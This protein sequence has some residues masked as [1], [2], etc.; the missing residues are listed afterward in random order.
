MYVTTAPPCP[1]FAGGYLF[2]NILSISVWLFYIGSG[3]LSLAYPKLAE[4]CFM[5]WLTRSSKTKR[6]TYMDLYYLFHEV[7]F[8]GNLLFAT[9]F[10]G[11]YFYNVVVNQV[12]F[13]SIYFQNTYTTY[14]A[15]PLISV[16]ILFILGETYYNPLMDVIPG[17][18]DEQREP[19]DGD[20]LYWADYLLTFIAVSTM[21]FIYLRPGYGENTRYS[22]IK[23]LTK[24]GTYAC[25]I[26]LLIFNVFYNTQ[27]YMIYK[28][29]S[30]TVITGSTYAFCVIIPLINIFYAKAYFDWVLS[31]MGTLIEIGLGIQLISEDIKSSEET[32]SQPK[33]VA[34]YISFF[35]GLVLLGVLMV[36]LRIAGSFN[37]LFYEY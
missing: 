8:I 23:I 15:V 22:Y 32:L 35:F 5:H 6:Y 14:T 37:R 17:E 16:S 19:S 11:I 30:E 34:G 12:D 7:C 3:W 13:L 20:L 28:E 4:G 31:I 29:V 18:G 33:K 24:K 1:C 25:L 2:N 21:F 9:T 27:A 36:N 26:S 10:I